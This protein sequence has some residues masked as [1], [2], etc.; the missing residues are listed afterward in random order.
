MTCPDM[1]PVT[2]AHLQR[3]FTQMRYPGMN[4]EQAMA[5]PIKRRCIEVY[6]HALRTREWE[7]TH[8]RTVVPVPRVRLGVDG[9]PIGHITDM[10][11]GPYE[12]ITQPSLALF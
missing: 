1:P 12:R 4:F 11:R 10:V 9:H 7:A 3:A 5:N 8:R 6:A 2:P